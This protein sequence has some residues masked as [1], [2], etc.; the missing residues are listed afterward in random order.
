M[1]LGNWAVAK[2]SGKPVHEM[3]NVYTQ[4]ETI[5]AFNKIGEF[6]DGAILV[7]EV[8]EANTDQLTTGHSGW[9]TNVKIWFVMIK[10]R[11]QRFKESDH[12]GDGW[13]CIRCASREPVFQTPWRQPNS[14]NAPTCLGS[15]SVS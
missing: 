3:H 11:K 14:L 9:A 15:L 8:R 1:H 2:E 5:A 13:G 10:D 6:P 4:P 7:K 12:W